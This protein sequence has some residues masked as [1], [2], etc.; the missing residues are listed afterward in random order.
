MEAIRHYLKDYKV[1]PF[2]ISD[3][4]LTFELSDSETKVTGVYDVSRNQESID[5]SADCF[6]DGE[7]LELVSVAVD[8]RRLD[9]TEYAVDDSGLI[10]KAIPDTFQLQ[11]QTRIHPETNFSCEGLYQ[12]NQMFCTQCEAHG[13]RRIIY[14]LDRPD[15]MATFQTKIIADKD[16]YPVL[17]S[18]GNLLDT[19]EE[20]HKHWAL[21][22]DP[23]KKPCYL[24]ALV[25]GDLACIQDHFTTAS[26]REVLCEFYVEHHNQDKCE[27]AMQ[28][29]HRAMKWDEEAYGRE[30]DL[31]RYMVVAVEDFNMGAMENKGLNIF[32][33]KFVLAS[34]ETATDS[35]YQYVE[36]VI[37]HEYFHNWTG[38]R[39]TC[40]DW[41]QLSLKEG[42]TV[43]REQSFSADM[44]SAS[45]KRIQDVR[46]LRATQFPEDSSPLAHPIK[47][48]SYVEMNNFYTAT[49][50]E[51]G[52]E[53]IRMMHTLLGVSGFRKGMDLYFKRHDGQAVTTEDF[54]AAMEEANEVDLAQF[55]H[56]Y[57]QAGTPHVSISKQFNNNQLILSCL[58]T[59]EHPQ[60]K[61]NALTLDIP[62][63]VGFIDTKGK[64]V[65]T[66]FQNQV[67]EEHLLRLTHAEQSFHFS[68]VPDGAIPSL[69]RGFSAPVEYDYSYSFEERLHLFKHDSDLFNRWEAGQ[70]LVRNIIQRSLMGKPTDELLENY[71]QVV[72]MITEDT[73]LDSAVKAELIALPSMVELIE[74][75]NGAD[76]DHLCAALDHVR[77]WIACQMQETFANRYKALQAKDSGASD[78][79]ARAERQLKNQLMWYLSSLPEGGF[80]E[81]I[82]HQ[83][84]S[85]H[86]MTNQEAALSSLV[87]MKTQYRRA[88]LDTFYEQWQAEAL[89]V[90][91]WFSLQARADREDVLEDVKALLGHPKFTYHNP[92]KV[93]ALIAAF[94][95]GNL[96]HFHRKD[97]KGY[98]FL[99]T[100][101]AIVDKINPQVAARLIRAIASWPKLDS[102]RQTVIRT[103]LHEFVEANELSKDVKELAEALLTP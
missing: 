72:G 83:F 24:F 77:A 9:E 65:K 19:G 21:W 91:K 92:N 59:I 82:Y 32:N 34:P 44:T 64:L 80:D 49:V 28:S 15:V 27:H 22:E 7:G 6:L 67:A 3:V 68:K 52:S 63:K 26:G 10:V 78:Y 35:D 23:F 55:K 43:F 61:D 30:Y 12:S 57:D 1:P 56:W 97:G 13:F 38:N 70:G 96:K 90:D 85:A 54:V 101:L 84:K 102:H 18:N 39:V 31:D 36:D 69:F 89:V 41:F 45:L 47:P 94:C 53:V 14:Y 8:G 76:F 93:R 37:G 60:H 2:L 62:I 40:R 66:E 29:L 73:E 100:Q 98:D 58:Q 42:L 103:K 48:K 88:S 99:F 75:F 5:K 81:I 74:Q 17:L 51:K 16:K 50:Y 95:Q 4:F 25:A 20:G 33:S 87:N 46:L 11:I 79:H 86:I 71:S